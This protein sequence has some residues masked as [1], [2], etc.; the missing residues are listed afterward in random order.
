MNLATCPKRSYLLPG[1][2]IGLVDI[3]KHEK[4][5]FPALYVEVRAAVMDNVMVSLKMMN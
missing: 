5:A 4:F 1:S 3:R 2:L